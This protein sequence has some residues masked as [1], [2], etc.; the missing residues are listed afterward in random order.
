MWFAKIVTLTSA[1]IASV[2]PAMLNQRRRLAEIMSSSDCVLVVAGGSRDALI[3]MPSSPGRP[4]ASNEE[5]V[6]WYTGSGRMH[7]ADAISPLGT[8]RRY[9]EQQCIVEHE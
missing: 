3:G 8:P 6:R 1:Q 5:P 2:A 4:H 9:F 7:E